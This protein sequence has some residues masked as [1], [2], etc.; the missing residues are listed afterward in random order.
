LPFD[1]TDPHQVLGAMLHELRAIEQQYGHP[2]GTLLFDHPHPTGKGTC[3]EYIIYIAL[4]EGYGLRLTDVMMARVRQ[5][6]QSRAPGRQP[7]RTASDRRPQ[8]GDR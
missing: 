2:T 4:P 8:N 3:L 6:M 1:P 5:A 7:P